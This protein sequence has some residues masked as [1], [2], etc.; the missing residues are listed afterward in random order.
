MVNDLTFLLAADDRGPSEDARVLAID[1][2]CAHAES[3]FT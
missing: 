3:A 1:S 2:V